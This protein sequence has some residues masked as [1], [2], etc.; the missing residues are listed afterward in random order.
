MYKDLCDTLN[1]YQYDYHYQHNSTY[2]LEEL[3]KD[4]F[5]QV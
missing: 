4:K 1:S 5:G 2:R 3:Q